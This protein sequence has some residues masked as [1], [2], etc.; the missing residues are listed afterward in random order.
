MLPIYT[1]K[2]FVKAKLRWLLFTSLVALSILQILVGMIGDLF[3]AGMMMGA[4]WVSLKLG[5]SE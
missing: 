4:V 3:V 5:A 2:K 1:I